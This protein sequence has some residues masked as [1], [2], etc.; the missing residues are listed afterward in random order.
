MYRLILQYLIN[1]KCLRT[2]KFSGMVG[3]ADSV[4]LKYLLGMQPRLR[5][6][7]VSQSDLEHSTV[8]QEYTSL[9]N[10]SHL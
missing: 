4:N 9:G 8:F 1:I 6:D 7:R 10:F 5:L 2:D 3:R